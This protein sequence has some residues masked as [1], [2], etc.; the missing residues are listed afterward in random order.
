[1]ISGFHMHL[2]SQN[3]HAKM[4]LGMVSKEFRLCGGLGM[5]GSRDIFS[6]MRIS[7]LVL[8]TYF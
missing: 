3:D 8:R 5:A 1:M 7:Q 6:L 4:I 2:Y